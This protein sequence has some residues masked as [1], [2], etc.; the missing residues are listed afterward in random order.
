[1]FRVKPVPD[2]Y[3][4]VGEKRDGL[5]TKEELLAA[6][7]I[8]AIVNIEFEIDFKPVSFVMST[9]ISGFTREDASN[10]DKFTGSQID[11]INSLKPGQKLYF[12]KIKAIGPDG[13]IRELGPM[14]FTIAE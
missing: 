4:R 5:I 3:A 6:G 7:G 9:V 1:M 8:N 10:S 11:L 12:E 13:A 2:P 14:I